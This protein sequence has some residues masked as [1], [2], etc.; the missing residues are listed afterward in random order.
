MILKVGEVA[1]DSVVEWYAMCCTDSGTKLSLDKARSALSLRVFQN[2][3]QRF[4]RERG[5]P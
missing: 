1:A 2:M 5:S 4:G 3:V